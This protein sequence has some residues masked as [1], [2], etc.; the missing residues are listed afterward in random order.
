MPP[1]TPETELTP[2]LL[3]IGMKLSPADRFRFV[4][5][6]LASLDPTE[7]VLEAE[8]VALRAELT[9]RWERLKSGED[10]AIPVE[11]VIAE[12]R[13]QAEERQTR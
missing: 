1:M 5:H 4:M 3:A 9:R 2:E 11:D 12:L 10:K 7:E 8:R 13:R 6:L